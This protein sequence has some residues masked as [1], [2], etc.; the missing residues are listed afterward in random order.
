[1]NKNTELTLFLKATHNKNI[2]GIKISHQAERQMY[3]L[4]KKENKIGIRL[5]I[6]KIGCAG[7]KHYMELIETICHTDISF[8]S[9]K[10]LIL[11]DSKYISI[12]DGIEID[13][14]KTGI[15]YVFKFNNKKIKNLCGCGES[16]NI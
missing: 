7:M 10:I 12:L 11:V 14:I 9:K 2:K 1:M 8:N 6:K 4:I 13:F 15:N 5:G 16:F 3:K